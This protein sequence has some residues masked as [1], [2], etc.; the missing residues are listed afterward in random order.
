MFKLE[1]GR[2]GLFPTNGWK[3]WLNDA[4]ELGLFVA[5]VQESEFCHNHNHD[6]VDIVQMIAS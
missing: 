2:N 1:T 3:P 6:G 4:P 5:D